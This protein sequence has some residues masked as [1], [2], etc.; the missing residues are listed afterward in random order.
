MPP[1]K[2]SSAK[3]PAISGHPV[4]KEKVVPPEEPV[5]VSSESESS[6]GVTSEE[7]EE[8]KEDEFDETFHD[9]TLERIIATKPVARKSTPAA[10]SKTDDEEDDEMEAGL[11]QDD[12]D[13]FHSAHDQVDS[14]IMM[15][16]QEDEEMEDIDSDDADPFSPLTRQRMHRLAREG[17]DRDDA[18]DESTSSET[19]SVSLK[20]KNTD[21]HES[22]TRKRSKSKDGEV[23]VLGE[24]YESSADGADDESTLEDRAAREFAAKKGRKTSALVHKGESSSPNHK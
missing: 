15:T 7:E 8:E 14:A 9:S 13:V 2:A 11:P 17:A 22:P 18:A 6:D 23:D 10:V 19:E 16:I 12:E 3:A 20:R 21:N 1:R 5:I 24:V 4:R